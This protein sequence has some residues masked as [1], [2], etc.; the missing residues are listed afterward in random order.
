MEEQV[1]M[2]SMTTEK[3]KGFYWGAATSAYQVEGNNIHSDWWSWERAD[4]T[5]TKAGKACDHYNLFD[6]DFKLASLLGHNAHR[7]SIEW[8]RIELSPGVINKRAIAHYREV[9]ES[10]KKHGLTSFVTL[11]H[12]T[13][14]NW[15][16]KRGGWLRAD[17]PDL[18]VKYVREVVINL[19]DL[20]DFW[21]TI[22]EP[23][24]YVSQSYWQRRWP[25]QEKSFVGVWRV[26]NNMARAHKLAYREIHRH[27]PN[28]SVGI[29]K[30]LVAYQPA[31]FRR[32]GDRW[33]A[34][35]EDWWFNHRFFSLTRDT[36][37][38]IG[39]NYYFLLKKK[40]SIIPL[41]VSS[42][43]GKGNKS[44]MGWPID[45][46]GFEQV[47]LHM[48]RYGRPIYVLENGIADAND[49]QRA[50]F[51]C[52]HLRAL[53]RAQAKGADVRGYLHWSL[54]DNY[55]WDKG[56]DP[57]FGLVEVDYET[58]VRRPRS[59]AYVMRAIIQQSSGS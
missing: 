44:D 53:E 7:L 41:R 16:A 20:V 6:D 45:A 40:F 33:V 56:F 19:G 34:A 27:Q 50:D 39:V 10:L 9:L 51:I 55:E 3:T 42:V 18:F 4:S 49:D 5:R 14:P 12:F 30:H 59:S 58:M 22:N 38:Y 1:Q 2:I 52:S 28:A 54:L 8:S 31:D 13:N 21:I 35:V 25:P 26:I 47:L 32:I 36:H 11:H 23:M 43:L 37:D 15:F 17:S 46:G 29:A 48:R 57:R 24:V